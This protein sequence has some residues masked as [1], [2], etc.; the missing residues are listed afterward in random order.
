MFSHRK[1]TRHKELADY[2]T[3][4]HAPNIDYLGHS[5]SGMPPNIKHGAIFRVSTQAL[6]GTTHDGG[7]GFEFQ[8]AL[9]EGDC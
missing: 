9:I 1:K 2:P 7:E 6:T 8:R 5:S 3:H 4:H